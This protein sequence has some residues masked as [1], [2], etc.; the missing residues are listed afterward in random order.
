MANELDRL[1]DLDPLELSSQDL[2]AIISYY[3]KSRQNYEL[4]VKPKKAGS[5]ENKASLDSL[6]KGM[7]PAAPKIERRF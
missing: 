6:I 2:D 3:R 7:A 4:G 5:E 1:M